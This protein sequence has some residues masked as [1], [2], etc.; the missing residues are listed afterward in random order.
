VTETWR[1]RYSALPEQAK[2]RAEAARQKNALIACG[3]TTN[4]DRVVPFDQ[5]LAGRLFAGRRIDVAAPRV[6]RADSVDDLLTGIA[7]CVAAGAGCDLPVRDAAVQDW[8]Q[9]RV[10]G[11][12]QIGGTGAQAAATLARLGF[13]V[14]LHLTG[15]S[16][17][18]IAALPA[19]EL[20]MIG[21]GDGLAPIE[22][23]TNPADLT[24]WHVVLEYAEGVGLP[25][26]GAS[27]APAGN[28]VIITYDPV[29]SAFTIDPGF[30]AALGDSKHEIGALLISGFSQLTER[31][32]LE[33]VLQDTARA[34][35]TWRAVRPRMPVHLE[36]GAMPEADSASRLLEMLHPIVTSIG[37]NI[38]ELRDLLR[39]LD[40]TMAQPGAELI[41]QFRGL[42]ERYPVPRWSL[43]TREFCVS[44]IDGDSAA[45]RDALLL[46]SL[47]AATRSRI[48]DFPQ[49]SD[50]QVTLE[51][52][53]VNPLGMAVLHS[54]GIADD[55]CMGD[56]LVV[57][58][59]LQ[60]E[61]ATASVGLGDSFTAGVLA[62]L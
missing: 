38:D 35:R 40:I 11:R 31:E 60:V 33:R 5:V 23:A 46:G 14:L 25:I 12:V 44:L 17:Q 50:L 27:P 21:S 1:R 56:T 45:E 54:L 2:A 47:V 48:S 29:N 51:R 7:Q 22:A 3:F 37:L 13:P 24:M 43:H 30:D 32:M 19:R 34:I 49:L 4:L 6:T 57:T 52:A 10:A 28:R 41:A 58:P 8:L 36:L 26:P 16:P 15:R 9:E 59:G 53:A 18:Q 39:G 20:M 62:M 55:G 42:A 61:G